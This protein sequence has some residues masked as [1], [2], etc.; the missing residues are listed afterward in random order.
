MSTEIITAIITASVTISGIILTVVYSVLHDRTENKRLAVELYNQREIKIFEARL[1]SYREI[2]SALMPLEKRAVSTLTPEGAIEIE[3]QL[4]VAFYVKASHCMSTES[5]EN[6]TI[7]RDSLIL[8]SQGSLEA[9]KLKDIRLN[10]LRSL[11]RDLGRTGFYL[12]SHKPLAETD[13][14]NIEKILE[15]KGKSA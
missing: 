14:K 1:E 7:L 15:S 6:L 5:I 13:S 8:F 10:L 2:F 11:H 12:G 3:Q 9:E 4:K